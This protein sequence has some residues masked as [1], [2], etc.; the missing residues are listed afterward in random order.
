MLMDML[1]LF[2]IITFVLF[3][4]SVYTM[5][6]N[7][8]LA[9]PLVMG[10]MVFSVLCTYGLW[11]VEYFYIGYNASVGNTSTHIYSTMDYGDPYSYIFVL[12]FFIFI[13]LFI[14]SGWN[15]WTEALETEGQLDYRN[16]RGR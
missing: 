9:I 15:L 12:L 2:I 6:T 4:L 3:I 1:M 10:G 13:L 8:F 14:R 5:E 11:D 7:P 16:R